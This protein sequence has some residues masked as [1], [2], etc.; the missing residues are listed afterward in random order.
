[1]RRLAVALLAASV[2]T[3]FA[4]AE[5]PEEWIMLGARVHGAFGA[6]IPVGIRIG[7]DALQRLDAKPREVTVLYYDS[8]KAP[9]ACFADG[10]ALAT[11]ATFGARTLRLAPEKAPE[12]EMAVVVVRNKKTGAAV[13]YTV[14]DT[15]IPKLAEWNRTLDPRGRYDEVMK[16]EGLFSA[17]SEK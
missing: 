3:G 6:Y 17:A 7:L 10:I 2:T 14:A 12:G 1:M 5:T 11:V 16:A 9:C 4:R 8:D 13:K 15:W